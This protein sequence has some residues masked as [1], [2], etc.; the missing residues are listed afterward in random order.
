MKNLTGIIVLVGLSFC[1]K[2]QDIHFS[3]LGFN[4]FY[5]SVASMGSTDAKLRAT[6][7]YRNQ[8][9]TVGK[10]FSTIGL[11]ADYKI[12]GEG[13]NN[14]GI[15]IILNRDVAGEL[16]LTKMQAGL[17]AAYHLKV[18]RNSHMSG[19]VQFGITQHSIDESAAEWG[20][21]YNGKEFDPNLPSRE[22]PLFA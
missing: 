20:N 22:Q 18:S 16:S 5:S 11:S 21:Q 10:S 13:D 14:M 7:H 15:G 2:A 4:S 12:K 8:W 6:S 19:G 17:A 3:N 1:V 9:P